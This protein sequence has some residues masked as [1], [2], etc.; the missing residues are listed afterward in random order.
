[1][2]IWQWMW[3]KI[4]LD[5]ELELLEGDGEVIH[6]HRLWRRS[7]LLLSTFCLLPLFIMAAANYYHYRQAMHQ[8][9]IQPVYRQ[10]SNMKRAL[11]FLLEERRFA[12]DFL[13][14]ERTLESLTDQKTLGD[15]LKH[16]KQTYGGFIDLGVIDTKGNQI[17]YVGPYDLMGKNYSEQ[18]WFHELVLR[19]ALVSDM[20]KGYRNFPHFVI[21]VKCDDHSDSSFVLRATVDMEILHQRIRALSLPPSSDAFLINRDGIFQTP[22]RYYGNVME[23]CPFP[24]PPLSEATEMIEE[25]F[26]GDQPYILAYSYIQ[27]SPFIFMAVSDPS[28]LQK[29]W[30][31]LRRELLVF[32]IV[33]TLVI[34][35]LILATSTYLVSR[36][37]SADQK[38]TY[39][40]HEMEYTN[41]MASIGRL[42]S[43]VAHEINNPMAI[44]YEKAGLLKDIL[45]MD[46]TCPN[47]ARILTLADSITSSVERC[48][49]ITHRM[50][51][52]AKHMD[53][54]MEPLDLTS[55]IH[56]VLGF[57]EKE[58]HY[59][60]VSISINT[61]D[62]C[63]MIQSDRGQLQ[64]VF[65][66]II[67]NAFAAV[68]DGGRIDIEVKA[69]DESNVT[70]IITDNGAGIPKE[71]LTHIFEPFFTTKKNYGTGLGLSITYGIVTKLGGQITVNSVVG[72]GT[73][74][75]VKLPIMK[76]IVG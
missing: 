25:T 21:A 29:N 44:I 8:Q 66:N 58:A 13:V 18:D 39:L 76:K 34:L 35:S 15:T 50:L 65:L 31:A 49:T 52:F 27:K 72:E 41:K 43:G 16:L 47:K 64:Q 69:L 62:D 23:Q 36:I 67:N 63:P 46:D 40:F 42:A 28:V 20:F 30:F 57:L 33:S 61:S 45:S 71:Y 17:S 3:K 11:G 7:V 12:L 24:V 73:T 10:T 48:R 5:E 75:T 22:S 38:R 51:G 1:M 74:F 60:D 4:V 54:Q 2:S 26:L 59:R 56:E 37:R 55:L 19:G 68:L 32:L 70:V 9:T 6:Y 14:R 53:M